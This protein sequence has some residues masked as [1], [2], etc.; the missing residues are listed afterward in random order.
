MS[1]SA[2]IQAQKAWLDLSREWYDVEPADLKR[3]TDRMLSW[4]KDNRGSFDC[5]PLLMSRILVWSDSGPTGHHPIFE[6][7][8]LRRRYTPD[9]NFGSRLCANWIRKPVGTPQ[10]LCCGRPVSL[11]SLQAEHEGTRF[12]RRIDRRSR[13]AW[14]SESD[15]RIVARAN[16]NCTR[17]VLS[18]SSSV[19]SLE[20]NEVATYVFA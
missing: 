16:P 7:C 17:S 3:A 9:A 5:A 6:F 2:V 15:R 14:N 1:G 10:A 20:P 8:P 19:A 11:K 12:P 4:T 18:G 13:A